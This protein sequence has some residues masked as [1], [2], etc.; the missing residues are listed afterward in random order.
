[1]FYESIDWNNILDFACYLC[2]KCNI[3]QSLALLES[4]DKNKLMV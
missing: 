4:R 2:Y 1:M 3:R